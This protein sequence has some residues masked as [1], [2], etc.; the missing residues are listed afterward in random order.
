MKSLPVVEKPSAFAFRI[1]RI[2]R[3]LPS[4]SCSGDEHVVVNR[5][6]VVE[7]Q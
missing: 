7:V 1:A 3:S 5:A 2:K 6:L 4:S